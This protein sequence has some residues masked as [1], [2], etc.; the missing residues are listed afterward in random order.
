[1]EKLPYAWKQFPQMLLS[2]IIDFISQWLSKIIHW[3]QIR[4]YWNTITGFREHFSILLMNIDFS[5]NLQVPVNFEPLSPHS[6]HP[7]ITV[8]SG[9][10]KFSSKRH[11]ILTSPQIKKTQPSVCYSSNQREVSRNWHKTRDNCY[12]WKW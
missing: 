4:H 12:H 11:T 9:L 8:H 5:E 7:W 2:F 3:N 10:V 6:S 1:M